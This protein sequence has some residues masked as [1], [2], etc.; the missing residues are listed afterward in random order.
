MVYD[1]KEKKLVYKDIIVKRITVP[2]IPG[3]LAYHEMD[4]Y[5]ILLDK[6][7]LTSYWPSV[8]VVDG[9]GQLHP[10]HVG[11]ACIVGLEYNCPSIGVAKNPFCGSL[12]GIPSEPRCC[13]K[14]SLDVCDTTGIWKQ[15]IANGLKET[16]EVMLM[17]LV[18]S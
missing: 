1:I 9:Q 10:R 11:T 12:F 17:I 5:R 13:E 4:V 15:T 16:R 14:N 18:D 7:K 6:L 2:Y 3:Y 8:F